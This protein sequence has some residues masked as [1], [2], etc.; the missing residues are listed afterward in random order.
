MGKVWNDTNEDGICNT[1]ETY[2]T[3]VKVYLKDLVTGEVKSSI[4]NHAGR[5]ALITNNVGEHHVV[6]EAP[7][8][9]VFTEKVWGTITNLTLM[10]MNWVSLMY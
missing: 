3:G 9:F 5:Y 6:V 7:D 8:D 2:E 1:G 4:T 10:L